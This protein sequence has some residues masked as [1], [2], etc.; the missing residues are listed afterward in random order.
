MSCKI[1]LLFFLII[2]IYIFIIL[3]FNINFI[4]IILINQ[5]PTNF[6]WT[7]SEKGKR[8]PLGLSCS[9][10]Q[11]NPVSQLLGTLHLES[12][13][14]NN[15]QCLMSKCYSA[16]LLFCSLFGTSTWKRVRNYN[17]AF[18]CLSKTLF[19]FQELKHITEHQYFTSE[20]NCEAYA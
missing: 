8:V 17:V 4:L 1:S 6:E 5:L 18:G 3:T 20:I 16:N 11:C 19:Y 9:E 2:Y 13:E 10:C 14:D 12:Y 15:I 7:F